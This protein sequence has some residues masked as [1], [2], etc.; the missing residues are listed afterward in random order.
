[1]KIHFVGDVHGKTDQYQKKLRQK[2]LGQ[3]TFQVGDM[4]IGFP[5]T[6]GLHKDIMG[7]THKWIRGNHDDPD[8]CA[9]LTDRG[10]LGNFG[11]IKEFDL[12]YVGGAFSIDHMWRVPGKSWWAGEENSYPELAEAINL[13]ER[14]KPKYVFSHDTVSSAATW[15]LTAIAGGFRSEK[16]L[17]ADSRTAVALEQMFQIHQ[18]KEWIFG[19]YHIDKSFNWKG[20]KFTCLNELNVYTITDEP[21]IVTP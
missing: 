9:Q 10:Y 16:M 14:V 5:G 20:T 8:K 2:F 1:M 12:F 13:Y 11:Y 17:S 18:P 6:P 3:N 7:D 15:L 4:G 21:L 19:H